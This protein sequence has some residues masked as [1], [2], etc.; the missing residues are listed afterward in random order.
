MARPRFLLEDPTTFLTWL[1]ARR[2]DGWASLDDVEVA[3]VFAIA[4]TAALARHDG[5]ELL[6]LAKA[7]ESGAARFAHALGIDE[8]LEGESER[9]PTERDRTVTLTRVRVRGQTEAVTKSIVNLM[10]PSQPSTDAANLFWFVLVELLRNVVQHSQDPAGGIVVAQ[11]N[12]AGPYEGAPALQVV[13]VDNGIGI[14]E[15]LRRTRPLVQ[16][17][18]EALTHALEP[19]VS[20]TFVEGESG[21]VEN[22]GLGLFFISEMAKKTKGRLLLASRGATYFLDRFHSANTQPVITNGSA[23][24]YPGTLVVFETALSQVGSY[25]EIIKEI[26]SVAAKRTPKRITYRWLRFEEAPAGVMRVLVDVAAEDTT[27]AH[28][29]SSKHLEPKLLRRESVALDFRNIRVCTQSFLHALL[30]E[31]V[32]LAW[33]RKVPMYVINATPTVRAQLEFV[34]GY[35]LGG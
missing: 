32:R 26:H 15:A 33:A 13:V 11:R 4:A 20:G 5:K 18:A 14:F 27:A 3:Q 22:A 6:H 23:S 2:Q 1:A 7:T 10:L 24:D 25:D 34:E 12:D 35:S 16:T 8:V 31:C 21:T 19:H 9:E 29:F 30:H 17:P 28:S